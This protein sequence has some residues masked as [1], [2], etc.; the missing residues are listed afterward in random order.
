MPNN[1]RPENHTDQNKGDQNQD[2]QPV[3]A[4]GTEQTGEGIGKTGLDRAEGRQ[5]SSHSGS[6]RDVSSTQIGC[7]LNV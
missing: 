6:E 3:S 7:G 1:W 5:Q 2:G 4:S